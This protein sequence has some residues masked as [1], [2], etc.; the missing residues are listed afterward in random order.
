MIMIVILF[1][2]RVYIIRK[3]LIF[4]TKINIKTYTKEKLKPQLLSTVLVL[5]LK[6]MFH[7]WALSR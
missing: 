5:Y 7:K 1:G 3:S 6:T 4:S 2:E